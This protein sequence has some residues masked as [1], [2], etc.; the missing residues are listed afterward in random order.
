VQEMTNITSGALLHHLMR[1]GMGVCMLGLVGD[2]QSEGRRQS[3]PAAAWLRRNDTRHIWGSW[4]NQSQ[5]SSS[6]GRVK[7]GFRPPYFTSPT[8]QCKSFP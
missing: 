2:V 6:S 7:H 8:C 3:A 1:P 4:V 5:T